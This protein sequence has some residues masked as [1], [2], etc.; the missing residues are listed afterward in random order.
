M[1]EKNWY[2]G[3]LLRSSVKDVGTNPQIL[4]DSSNNV[5]QTGT[6]NLGAAPNLR[7]VSLT[8]AKNLP[9]INTHSYSLHLVLSSETIVSNF[10]FFEVRSLWESEESFIR[11]LDSWYTPSLRTDIKW[12][13][14]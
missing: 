5:F 8:W 1:K 7:N 14:I 6:F 11:F 13:Y 9:P 3:L 10:Y 4:N 12:E 2:L